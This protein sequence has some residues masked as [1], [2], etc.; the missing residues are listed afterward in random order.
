MVEDSSSF[1]L[2]V[3]SILQEDVCMYAH[4]VS[5]HALFASL[6]LDWGSTTGRLLGPTT[7]VPQKDGGIPLSVLPKDKRQASLFSTLSLFL[8]SAKQ[9]SCEYHFLK[10]FGMT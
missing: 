1:E 10:S 5:A 2:F 6:Q 8:L 4:C 7:C 9:G 3:L